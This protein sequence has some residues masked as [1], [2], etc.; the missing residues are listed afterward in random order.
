MSRQLSDLMSVLTQMIAEQ[1]RLLAQMDLQHAAMKKLDYKAMSE[2]LNQE[3]AGRLRLG[4]L[5]GRRRNLARQ[6]AVGLKLGEEPTLV[7][8]A[9]LFPQQAAV[10]LS[11]RNELRDVIE[12]ISRRSQ[13]S[14]RLSSAV[15]GHLNTA[16]R[17]LASAVERAGVYTRRGVPRLGTRIGAMEAVG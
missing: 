6:I 9:E 15:L 5:E 3:E 17:L 14:S 8:L 4:L 13:M 10:L 16:M 2:L 11:L 12:K 1:K 7:Q